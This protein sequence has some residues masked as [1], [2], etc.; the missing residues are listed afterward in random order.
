M[1]HTRIYDYLEA[2]RTRILDWTR[3]LTPE[4][5]LKQLPIGLGS[6]GRTLTH[7]YICEYYYIERL[8]GRE[9]PPYEEWPIQDEKPPE[10]AVLERAWREQAVR[11]RA[12]LAAV[13]DWSAPLRYRVERR[14]EAFDIEATYDGMLIQM[15]Q[16]EVHHRAQAMNMLRQLGVTTEDIDYN[17]LMYKRT[18]VA[19]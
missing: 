15:L 8:A 6:I 7:I 18:P 11:T 2:S 13:S 1:N 4:Q 19:R 9:T 12:E 3:P 17:A 14:G 16:H 5:Y 10:F